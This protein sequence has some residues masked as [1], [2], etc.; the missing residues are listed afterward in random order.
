MVKIE[1]AIPDD[2]DTSLL[3]T[4][5]HGN[6]L[7]RRRQFHINFQ[8]FLQFGNG[9]KQTLRLRF[10]LDIDVDRHRPPIVQQ[11]G[12]PSR[13]I[14]SPGPFHLQPERLQKCAQSFLVD[15]MPHVTRINRRWRHLFQIGTLPNTSTQKEPRQ[16]EA[17]RRSHFFERVGHG[18]GIDEERDSGRA[19]PAL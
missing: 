13:K 5:W 16:T 19:V 7:V 1:L 10:C 2:Q 9:L 12:P 18:K 15:G 6:E 17:G 4:G 11:R 14:D 3:P 8:A